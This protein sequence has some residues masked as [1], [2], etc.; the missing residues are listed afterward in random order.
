MKRNLIGIILLFSF[1]SYVFTASVFA[2]VNIKSN[3]Y[4]LT[5]TLF[6]F[7]EVETPISF[8][9]LVEVSDNN[10]FL[11]IFNNE[12]IDSNGNVIGVTNTLVDVE[13]SILSSDFVPDFIKTSVEELGLPTF[14]SAGFFLLLLPTLLS[15]LPLLFS[16][17]LLFALLGTLFGEKKDV[18]GIVFDKKTKKPIPFVYVRLFNLKGTQVI[19]QKISDLNGR[20]G[21]LL[22]QGEYRLEVDHNG[23][24]KFVKELV[25]DKNSDL[26]TEDI[27]LAENKNIGVL[28][29]FSRGLGGIN[30]FFKRFAV[31][32][33]IV[34]FLF[35]LLAFYLGRSNLSLALL[36]FYSIILLV[37]FFLYLKRRGRRWGLVKDSVTGLKVGGAIVKVFDAS[38]RLVDTQISDSLG[39]FAVFLDP[40]EYTIGVQSTGYTFPSSVYTIGIQDVKGVSLLKLVINKGSWVDKELMVDKN[41]KVDSKI[42][43]DNNIN[44]TQ[45]NPFS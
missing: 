18:L 44:N 42:D 17:Q 2:Q 27:P 13:N 20:Y 39:R 14:A 45:F 9:V 37:Y 38:N 30:R 32:I 7:E 25:I 35:A 5:D 24:G 28:G 6:V 33:A 10:D 15:I 21:F 40:G 16:P 43:L 23:Y 34:G 4:E 11:N 12:V 31:L 29:F 22:T 26:F 19:A 8:P 3:N 36:I 41:S 1:L